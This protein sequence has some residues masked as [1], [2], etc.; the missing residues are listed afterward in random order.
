[1]P[2]TRDYK[3]ST[4]NGISQTSIVD[5]GF[6]SMLNPEILYRETSAATPDAICWQ[7]DPATVTYGALQDKSSETS[8]K[9]LSTE[10]AICPVFEFQNPIAEFFGGWRRS[11]SSRLLRVADS[12]HPCTA[13]RKIYNDTNATAVHLLARFMLMFYSSSWSS[14]TPPHSFHPSDLCPGP[15]YSPSP[16]AALPHPCLPYPQHS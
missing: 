3:V 4:S 7:G 2:C 9:N 5:T 13:F 12:A 8:T 14:G 10:F 16:S 1:M 11:Q 6:G 15:A